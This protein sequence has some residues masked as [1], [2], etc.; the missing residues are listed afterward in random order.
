MLTS[1]S[2]TEFSTPSA[3]M[4]LIAFTTAAPDGKSTLLCIW[5]PT[6]SIG[7][8]RLFMP[9]TSAAMNASLVVSVVLKS[10]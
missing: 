3:S 5:W 6:P 10:L 9:L 1:S 7:T 4:V 2:V 8:P